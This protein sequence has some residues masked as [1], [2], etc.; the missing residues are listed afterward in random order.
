MAQ[1]LGKCVLVVA[2]HPDDEVL[3]CGATL[4]RLVQEGHS[5][6]LAFL[7]DGVGSRQGADAEQAE[8]RAAAHRSAGIMGIETVAFFDL[9][10]N[11]LDTVPL[12]DVIRSVEGLIAR[13]APATVITHHAGDVNID[14]Q[15]CHQAVV[16]ACRP[17]PGCPVN[18]LLSFEV[19]SSTEWQPPQSAL[20]FA[21]NFFVD[22]SAYLSVKRRALDAYG[23][24]M[25]AWPHSRSYEA[26]EHLAR[27]RGASVGCEAAEAFVVSRLVVRA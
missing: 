6:H 7:A 23:S 21:P 19:P 2:A 4:A 16:T 17:Q 3:G 20:P 15:R 1:E 8:R 9:P 12:L 24:E 26:V 25:R 11:R 5:V 14:H 22:I 27:W 10:D 13:L 18:C